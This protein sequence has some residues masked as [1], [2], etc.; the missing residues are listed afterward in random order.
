[1]ASAG[2]E[3][4]EKL[5]RRRSCV[6]GEG[7]TFERA[8]GPSCSDAKAPLSALT[9]DDG[10]SQPPW[11]ATAFSMGIEFKDADG[12]PC[13]VPLPA[14][15]KHD[16]AASFEAALA[17]I[18]DFERAVHAKRK[19]D[20]GG[21]VISIEANSKS[22]DVDVAFS[23]SALERD[24]AS[25]NVKAE[26]DASTPESGIGGKTERRVDVMMLVTERFHAL[27]AAGV[28]PNAAAAQAIVEATRQVEGP[29]VQVT[30]PRN[31][32]GDRSE[33][34]SE[35]DSQCLVVSARG[36]NERRSCGSSAKTALPR[37]E[38]DSN[39]ETTVIA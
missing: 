23:S 25:A 20:G 13:D 36:G 30:S 4:A 18:R 26:H 29:E 2:T 17:K 9:Q 3:L 19:S 5:A 35:L 7:T 15:R 27:V 34:N 39:K 6:D 1:M 22:V 21:S 37:K 16:G 33:G 11:L 12:R 8:G 32:C 24:A 38:S 31:A 14:A 10:D 28:D